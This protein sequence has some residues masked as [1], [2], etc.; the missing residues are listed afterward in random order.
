MSLSWLTW[1]GIALSI[2]TAILSWLSYRKTGKRGF[3]VA[4][5]LFLMAAGLLLIPALLR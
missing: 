4:I 3:Q 5:G 1:I 2:I